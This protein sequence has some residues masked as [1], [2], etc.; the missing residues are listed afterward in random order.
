MLKS[1]NDPTSNTTLARHP[2]PAAPDHPFTYTLEPLRTDGPDALTPE[3]SEGITAVRLRQ[4][5]VSW[6]DLFKRILIIKSDDLFNS[7]TADGDPNPIPHGPNLTQA[8]IEI[9]FA[10]STAPESVEIRPP[11]VLKCDYPRDTT[12]IKAFLS[13]HHFLEHDNGRAH[14]LLL[15]V[16]TALAALSQ[17]PPWAHIEDNDDEHRHHALLTPPLHP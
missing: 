15:A 10:D 16:A 11:K 3:P 9:Q 2:T 8:T 12:R 1:M 4:L 7:T 14:A 17:D 5:E 6:D 13:K